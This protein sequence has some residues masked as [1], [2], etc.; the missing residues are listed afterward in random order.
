MP[1]NPHPLLLHFPIALLIVGVVCDL[2][3][4][5]PRRQALPSAAWWDLASG[6]LAALAAVAT[7]PLSLS[8]AVV[9]LPIAGGYFGGELVYTCGVTVRAV[10]RAPGHPHEHPHD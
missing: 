7:F 2:L 3:G 6:G 1:P 5:A 4:V 8:L 10:E 9:G